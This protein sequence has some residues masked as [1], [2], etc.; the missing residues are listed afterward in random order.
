MTEIEI[1]EA[2]Y[3]QAET[4]CVELFALVEEGKI[5]EKLA[6]DVCEMSNRYDAGFAFSVAIEKYRIIVERNLA[7]TEKLRDAVDRHGKASV[8]YLTLANYAKKTEELS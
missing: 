4:E 1:A 8:K 5:L 6:H 7:N 3:R 2:E